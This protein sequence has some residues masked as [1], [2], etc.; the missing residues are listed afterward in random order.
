MTAVRRRDTAPERLVRREVHALGLRYFVDRPPLPHLR[1]RADLVFPR[2]QIAVFVDGCF[3]HGCELHRAT[4]RANNAWW[5]EKLARTRR[6]DADTDARLREAGWEVLRIWEHE[7][8]NEVARTLKCMV[9]IRRS[10]AE[11]ACSE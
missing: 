3:W 11:P 7:E 4:P 5:R 9:E 1:R 6:R 2:L 8:P 10:A